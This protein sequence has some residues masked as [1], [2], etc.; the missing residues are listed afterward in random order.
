MSIFNVF[1][2]LGGLALFLFGM[3]VM[4][5]A[6]EKQAG[7]KLQMILSRLTDNPF[8]GFLLGL[9]VTAII[10]SSSA[11]TV[12]VVGFVNSGL[13]K[14]HQ[15]IGIIMG[16]NVGTTVTAWLLSLTGLKGDSFWV[17]LCKPSTFAPLLAFVGIFLYMF[18][19][20]EKKKGIGTILLGFAVLM[21]GMEL[22][23]DAVS[24][25]ADEPWFTSL[26]TMFTN[27]ILGVLAGAILTGI[28][29]SS[30]ASVGILQALSS[31][32]AITYGSALPIIMGQN[33]GTCVTALLSSIGTNKNAKRA[34]M[35]HLYFNIIGV[36]VFL[37]LF[38]T[39]N[40]FIHFSFTDQTIN[41]VGIAVIHTTFNVLATALLLPFNRLLEKLAILTIPDHKEPEKFQLLDERLLA[42]PTVAV[43]NARMLTVEMAD[44]ARSSLLQT[45]SLTHKWDENLAKQVAQQEEQIDLYEDHLGTYLVQLSSQDLSLEDSHNVS[46]LLH[47]IGDFERIGDHAM[48]LLDS[49]KEI[50]EKG[51]AFSEGAR[52]E[53][54]VLEAAIQKILDLAIACFREEEPQMAT[55]VEPL[56][57]VIDG[58]V[59]EMK[60]RHIQRLQSGECTIVLGF[61]LTDLLTNYERVADHCSNIAV[62]L[63]QVLQ[64]SFDTHQYLNEMN[65]ENGSLFQSMLEQY[66]SSYVLPENASVE[67]KA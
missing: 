10:Q 64:G 31:T 57:D 6:L 17:Q 61:V 53:L 50:H 26:F 21:T 23:S 28:I 55:Q 63:I 1:T 54:A 35:V 62:E 2:L 24:P 5:N 67:V 16:S 44:L 49:A 29:Q 8:K 9:G 52:Q 30:S 48:N 45:M 36:V 22:M 12:M 14:L 42:T 40:S 38:Y 37:A 32:G 3:D 39:A 19:K 18:V 11:T 65:K 56:E 7:N 58:L 59:R 41:A 25:L 60:N 34:A 51:I 33:I 66:R 46:L 43:E 13:M 4:G 15:A 47:T 20:S 27:P